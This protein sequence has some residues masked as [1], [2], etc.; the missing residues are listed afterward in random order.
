MMNDADRIIEAIK[1]VQG[2][3]SAEKMF[4]ERSHGSR[5][6]LDTGMQENSMVRQMEE[7]AARETGQTEMRIAMCEVLL[8]R[9]KNKK[10]KDVEPYLSEVSISEETGALI[11]SLTFPPDRYRPV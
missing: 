3:L 1:G 6:V 5:I 2:A 4:F 11:I 9:I 8:D 7:I 10:G